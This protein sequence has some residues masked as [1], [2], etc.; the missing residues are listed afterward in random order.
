MRSVT[1]R[2]TLDRH[3]DKS[4]TSQQRREVSYYCNDY[5][6]LEMLLFFYGVERTY[7]VY[8]SLTNSANR[9]HIARESLGPIVR[10]RSLRTFHYTII[11]CFPALVRTSV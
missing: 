6:H 8:L 10:E 4:E 11:V 5:Y 1:L 2:W 7:S 9:H 3:K